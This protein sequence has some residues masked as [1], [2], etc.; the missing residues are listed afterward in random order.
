M[1]T[2]SLHHF[3]QRRTKGIFNTTNK[4]CGPVELGAQ[5]KKNKK[6]NIERHKSW[7]EQIRPLWAAL[8]D[9]ALAAEFRIE[10]RQSFLILLFL[11]VTVIFF[12]SDHVISLFS[13]HLTS[14]TQRHS[15]FLSQ[16]MLFS[17]FFY[18]SSGDI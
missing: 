15:S 6:K 13:K 17:L 16:F 4:Y 5:L 12:S 18:R 7:S 14:R 3:I 9:N 1:S 11:I 10:L 8:S 2:R